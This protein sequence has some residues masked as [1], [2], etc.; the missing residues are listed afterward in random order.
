MHRAGFPMKK[1]DDWSWGYWIA[2]NVIGYVA[3]IL[4]AYAVMWILKR[5]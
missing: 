3:L 2:L 5:R 4:F 1:P